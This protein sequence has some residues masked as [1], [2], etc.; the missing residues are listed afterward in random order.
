MPCS[1]SQQEPSK[2]ETESRKVS[3]LIIW[4]W[5]HLDKEIPGWVRE[6]VN[7]AYGNS[8]KV[9]ELTNML[10]NECR[11]LTQKG[12]D[13][14]IYNGRDRNARRLADWWDDHQESD[15]IMAAAR[16]SKVD[17]LNLKRKALSKLTPEERRAIQS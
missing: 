3:G 15:R 12:E 6:T 13:E 4:L 7:N 8:E 5:T 14:V 1:S 2:Q 10:C 16:Q 11:V 17:A 9:H